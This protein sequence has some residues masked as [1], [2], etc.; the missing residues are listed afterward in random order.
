MLVKAPYK[1][2]EY[3]TGVNV[4]FVIEGSV[5][6]IVIEADWPAAKLV[7]EGSVMYG[8]P[9]KVPVGFTSVTPDGRPV[10]TR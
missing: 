5:K 4:I 10:R 6:E 3:T 1:A 2:P 9:L 8:L 7:T